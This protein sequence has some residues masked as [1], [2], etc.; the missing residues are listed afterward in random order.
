MMRSFKAL[1]V[2]QIIINRFNTTLFNKVKPVI[3]DV[4]KGF[5]L[6]DMYLLTD[7]QT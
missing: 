2:Q 1:F 3:V 5:L 7:I 6:G 4:V